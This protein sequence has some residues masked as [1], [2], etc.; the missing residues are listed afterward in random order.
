[1]VEILEIPLFADRDRILRSIKTKAIGCGNPTHWLLRE[2][3]KSNELMWLRGKDLDKK[4][5]K[6]VSVRRVLYYLAYHG[7]PIKRITMK[8]DEPERCINPCHMRIRGFESEANVYI[9]EQIEKGWLHPSDAVG[10]FGTGWP[11]YDEKLL[12]TFDPDFTDVT[13]LAQAVE[14]IPARASYK[15]KQ[16]R[17][18]EAERVIGR[19]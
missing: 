12:K 13:D 4:R 19:A 7:L 10:M 11:N 8:C 2:P 9:L 18:A 3:Y 1:M 17:K 15:E 16:R 5:G 6:K 14:E